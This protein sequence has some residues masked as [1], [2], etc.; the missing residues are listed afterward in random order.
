MDVGKC[1]LGHAV[2]PKLQVSAWQY[3]RWL[4]TMILSH[5]SYCE[6]GTFADTRKEKPRTMRHGAFVLEWS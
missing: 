4:C 6:M 2:R 5:F 3:E 1:G